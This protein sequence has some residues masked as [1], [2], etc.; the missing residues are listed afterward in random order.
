MH[1]KQYRLAAV[2]LP[3]GLQPRSERP[4]LVL[5]FAAPEIISEAGFF[6]V[7]TAAYP[8][9]TLAGCS[10]AGEILYTEVSDHSAV[11]TEITFASCRC[12][13]VSAT[14]QNSKHSFDAGANLANKIAMSDLRAVM[15]F[16]PG[17]NV[18]GSA[19]VDGIASVLGEIPISGGLAG[20]GGLFEK[21]YILTPEGVDS[22]ALTAV[23]LYGDA[24]TV[25]YSSFGGW[26][27]FGPLRKV[28]RH[29][30]NILHE[31]DGRPA[32]DL[33]KLY[34]GEY[35][36][37][38][39]TSGLYFPLEMTR[40]EDKGSGIIRTIMGLDDNSGSLILAGDIDPKA[41][42]RLM[43]TSADGLINGAD[44]AASRIGHADK[45][46]LALLVSCFGRRLMMGD[47]VG[48][49]AEVVSMRLGAA[50][51][52]T[53][54]YSFGEI[55]PSADTHKCYFHNQTMTISV[56]SEDA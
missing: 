50:T 9:S 14:I 25:E 51:M 1:V 55:C 11:V 56:I 22:S 27:P 10:T 40:P 36:S 6:D 3:S 49:E 38:L 28:T 43:H 7:L 46:R 47:E 31:L 45:F 53:G 17:V 41:Y 35:A 37:E 18:N 32:V 54:F 44:I 21:T 19:I 15:V 16:G 20:D 39:P 4:D 24:L 26:Q 42:M 34:L 5:I 29:E 12:T 23:C 33:Y 30:D 52:T 48:E 13:A 2:D 8:D